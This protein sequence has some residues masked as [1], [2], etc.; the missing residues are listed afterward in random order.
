MFYRN[1][2][3]VNVLETGDHLQNNCKDLKKFRIHEK[4][5]FAKHENK[6]ELMNNIDPC[7]TKKDK[8]TYDQP[9][10]HL[11]K[12]NSYAK[13]LDDYEEKFKVSCLGREEI[14]GSKDR[15]DNRRHSPVMHTSSR[16]RDYVNFDTNS[17]V[18]NR[19]KRNDQK[20]LPDRSSNDEKGRFV[21]LKYKLTFRAKKQI[22]QF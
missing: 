10:L 13:F 22:L 19:H 20:Y 12:M 1:V 3:N 11:P 5:P 21:E 8:N 17:D 7:K 14:N 16:Q 15:R 6:H 2:N 18:Q 4:N 9:R